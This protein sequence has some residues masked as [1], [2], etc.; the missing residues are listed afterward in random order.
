MAYK[1]IHRL[2]LCS[3][4]LFFSPSQ[5]PNTPSGARS[6]SI[7]NDLSFFPSR[8]A[9]TTCGARLT[10]IANDHT[11]LFSLHAAF[12]LYIHPWDRN[13]DADLQT[14]NQPGQ[15]SVTL[16]LLFC[17]TAMNW[18]GRKAEHTHLPTAVPSW[19]RKRWLQGGKRRSASGPPRRSSRR[20]EHARTGIWCRVAPRTEESGSTRSCIQT[21]R[22]RR[23]APRRS[24]SSG[25]TWLIHWLAG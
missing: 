16:T 2:T 18:T 10:S 1:L 14:G 23:R 22:R 20:G 12:Q 3:N 5:F 15:D 8:F 19:M 11:T 6:T 4:F 9:N 24:L 7:A 21:D 25:V 17:P 13:P